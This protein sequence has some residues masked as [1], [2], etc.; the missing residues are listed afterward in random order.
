MVPSNRPAGVGTLAEDMVGAIS[1][2]IA[3]RWWILAIRGG[4]ALLFG[5]RFIFWSDATLYALTILWSLYAIADGIVAL[6]AGIRGR[7]WGMI[8]VGMVGILAGLLV[9]VFPGAAVVALATFIGVWVIARGIFEIVAAI[10]LRSE[11]ENEWSLIAGGAVSV[12]YGVV[13]LAY[14][15][16]GV[17]AWLWLI[18]CGAILCGILWLVL[19]FR[20]KALGDRLPSL[21]RP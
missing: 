9:F 14:P 17:E 3:R 16:T 5:S 4:L 11:I 21:P 8:V 2:Q 20:L 7:W 12:I 13:L 19:A 15:R 1:S 10:A 6:S 18:G